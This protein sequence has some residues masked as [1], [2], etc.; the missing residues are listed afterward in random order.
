M[1]TTSEVL[2]I[3]TIHWIADFVCQ[4]DWMAINKSKLLIALSFHCFVYYMVFNLCLG[5]TGFFIGDDIWIKFV[6]NFSTFYTIGNT[7]IH[8]FVDYTTSRINSWLWEKGQRHWFFVMIGL[9]Q[10]IHYFC[11]FIT[12]EYALQ[13]FHG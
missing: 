13:H 4:S 3:L 12:L 9:D 6:F 1:V 10:L 2:A 8:F 5:M 11:L 7:I